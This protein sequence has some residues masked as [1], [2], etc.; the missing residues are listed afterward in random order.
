MSNL[1]IFN[2]EEKEVRTV[3]I[4]NEPYFISKDVAE[5]LGYLEPHKAL[6]RHVDEDD[7]MK[8]PITDD[9]GRL[10]KT[11]IINESGLYSLI[12]SSKLSNAKKFKRW[13]TS[14][15]LPSIR[16][17][18]SYGKYRTK[19]TSAGEVASLVKTTASIM[20]KQ[21]SKPHEVAEQTKLTYD[22]FGI[23]TIDNFVKSP[24][25]KARQLTMLLIET[26]I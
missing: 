6:S 21:K 4:N 18:G 3:V 16:K 9:L 19:A 15:V 10:Q 24:E 8:H 25:E 2:F 1:Q 20:I 13:V 23:P 11:W 12:L 26:E 7:R 5:V 14:E 17:T 22:Y